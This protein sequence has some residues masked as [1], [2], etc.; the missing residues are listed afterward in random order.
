MPAKK[1]CNLLTSWAKYITVLQRRTDWLMTPNA[2][3]DHKSVDSLRWTSTELESGKIIKIK[4]FPKCQKVKFGVIV[5]INK[6]SYVAT[7]DRTQTTT[8]NV[9]KV[10]GIRWK[11]E[12]FHRELKQLKGIDSS[13]VP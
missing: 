4:T 10:C 13:R 12:E 8:N 2:R 6:R 7:N 1:S 9:Q 5:S 11:I 3:E